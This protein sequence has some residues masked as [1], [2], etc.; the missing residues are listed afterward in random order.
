MVFRIPKVGYIGD[1]IKTPLGFILY[2]FLPVVLFIGIEIKSTV[3]EDN[4]NNI[5]HHLDERIEYGISGM[6][7]FILNCGNNKYHIG[8]THRFIGY[9]LMRGCL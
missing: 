5:N 9:Y 4:Q 7:I 2:I 1:L 8:L 3:K 6:F